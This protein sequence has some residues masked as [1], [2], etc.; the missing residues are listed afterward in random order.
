MIQRSA[1]RFSTELLPTNDAHRR[2]RGAAL[3]AAVAVAALG[4]MSA[5]CAWPG[6][7]DEPRA[8][9]GRA[10]SGAPSAA[11]P[12]ISNLSSDV[13]SS[14]WRAAGVE[15]A[16]LA[17]AP[18][19]QLL[20][21]SAPVAGQY[22]VALRPA[23]VAAAAAARPRGAAE[24]VDELTGAARGELLHRYAAS[25]A[26]GFVGFAARM[27]EAEARKLL[28][29]PRV[30]Y[31]E[32]DGRFEAYSTQT[33][34]PV[35][36]D[37][38]DQ[39]YRP[40]NGNYSYHATGTGVHAYVL[41]TG[42]RLTHTQFTGRVGAG[43]D[44]V[45]AGG[46]AS[47]CH[48][49]GT[50]VAGILGGTTYGVAKG[51]ILHPVRVLNCT[52]TGTT[53]AVIA[54]V[55]WV[56]ANRILP[57]VANMS[58]GG[59]ASTSVSSAVTA[60]INAGVVFTTA[61]AASSACA[62]SPAN[63]PAVLTS[64]GSTSSDVVT[65]FGSC[66]D[67]YAPGAGILSAGIGSDT[68]AVTLSGNSMSAPHVAG[69]AALYLQRTPTA[70]P[71]QVAA[72][73]I[74]TATEGVLTGSSPPTPNRLLHNGLDSLSLR[75]AQSFLVVAEGGGGSFLAADRLFLSVAE[76]YWD[77]FDLE[78][79][80]G[81]VLANGD[82]VHLRAANGSYVVAVSGGGSV[83]NATSAIAA[84]FETFRIINVL[85]LPTFTTGDLVALES[86]SGLF[87]V[88][89]N[90][91]GVSGAGSVQATSVGVGAWEAFQITLP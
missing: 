71:A 44:A 76:R 17:S 83:V 40:L 37:R 19:G 77:R 42:L 39:R 24:L 55:N 89:Q 11:G 30:A 78:D 41:D 74:G 87:V 5:S 90:G 88:A 36:L 4:G 9:Q 2:R 67:L 62:G 34:A 23:A 70:T 14:S 18:E 63:L 15:S 80:N 61:A 84:G 13:H 47:D 54:G 65:T 27:S 38:I 7:A 43:F 12:Q 49:H 69:V 91:G 59:P 75:S 48:G 79:V 16:A 57:A 81:G 56:T 50:H 21:A 66:I 53:S 45:T 86:A 46:N 20:R 58:L 1:G 26:E 35:G 28:A 31:V 22:I 3:R 29:D 25:P 6:E 64:A 85:G 73:L 33:G 8:P 52:G 10:P 60:A 32:E 72:R 51:V 82:L 68:A